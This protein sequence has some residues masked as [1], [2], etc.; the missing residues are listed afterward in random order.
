[1]RKKV[2]YLDLYIGSL[3]KKKWDLILI[4]EAICAEMY[5]RDLH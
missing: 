4:L 2:A 1:M 3:D 5:L